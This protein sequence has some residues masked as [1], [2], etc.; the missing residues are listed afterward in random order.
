MCNMVVHSQGWLCFPQLV[1]GMQSR[2]VFGGYYEAPILFRPTYVSGADYLLTVERGIIDL[3]PPGSLLPRNMT[4]SLISTTRARSSVCR[5]GRT[6]SC[7]L[8]EK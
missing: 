5:L 6:E 3:I 1:A 7:T 8:D 4:T 2:G